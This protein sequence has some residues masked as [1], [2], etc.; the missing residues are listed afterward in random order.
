MWVPTLSKRSD[1]AVR[2]IH[3]AGGGCASRT[4]RL[5]GEYSVFDWVVTEPADDKRTDGRLM[6]CDRHTPV[7]FMCEKSDSHVLSL[8]IRKNYVQLSATFAEPFVESLAQTWSGPA[9]VD[10]LT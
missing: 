10:V 2:R 9:R 5:L 1:A 6:R 7:T 4:H 3:T 8:Y